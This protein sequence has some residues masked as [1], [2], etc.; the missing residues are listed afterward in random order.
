MST[1]V[2]RSIDTPR[3]EPLM[4][5]DTHLMIIGAGPFGLSAAAY[6]ADHGIPHL[7]VG[8]PMQFWKENMPVGMLLRSACDWH[9]DPEGVHTMV[10]YLETRGQTPAD[11]EPLSLS[12]YLGYAQWFQRAKGLE[13]E[14]SHVVEL[15]R[16]RGPGSRF[17]ALLSGGRKI[18]AH[19]VLIAIGF[20]HF[21]HIPP[22]L[23]ELLPP[24]RWSH[25]CDG[26]RLE[27]FRGQ[28]VLIIGGRQSA[29]EWAALIHEAGAAAVDVS[30][31]HATPDFAEADWSWVGPIVDAMVDDPGWYRKLSQQ[32]KDW[33]KQRLWAEGRLK[34]EPWL[35]PRLDHPSI[36]LWPDTRLTGCRLL[37]T[38]DL[39]AELDGGRS[40]SV[41]RVVLATGYQ[42]DMARIP[43]LARGGLLDEL[44]TEDG[45]PVLD[46][47][48]Q[49]SVP[50]LFITS[51]PATRD[52]GPF[53]AFTVSVRTSATIVGRAVDAQRPKE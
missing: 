22:E 33:I 35:K 43:F 49:A 24:G 47:S 16:T 48:L 46:E 2:R 27:T 29:L 7:L 32:E 41:D 4:S 42:V 23:S 6:A 9:L 25:T 1:R 28:R 17:E 18:T 11:V 19:N 52:F 14:G 5:T 21:A 45:H 39:E 3:P 44:D 15:R 51:M 8:T 12:T 36:T 50:G 38:G 31:R 13:A 53:F 34:V 10:R 37:P 40:V 30:H 20:R 26:V